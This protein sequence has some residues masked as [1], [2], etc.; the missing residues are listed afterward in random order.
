MENVS[1]LPP[2]LTKKTHLH[3]VDIA[4]GLHCHNMCVLIEHLIGDRTVELA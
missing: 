4:S 3:A 1:S 2:S